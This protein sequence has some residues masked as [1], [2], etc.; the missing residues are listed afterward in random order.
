MTSL[1]PPRSRRRVATIAPRTHPQASERCHHSHASL[2][3][4]I[5]EHPVRPPALRNMHGRRGTANSTRA[6]APPQPRAPRP[7]RRLDLA[8]MEPSEASL[9]APSGA[10]SVEPRAVE[11]LEA[12]L[13]RRKGPTH[14]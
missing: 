5:G 3:V 13:R 14:D 6:A 12:V 8:G 4:C 1:K 11:R 7:S 9:A 10:A 2:T